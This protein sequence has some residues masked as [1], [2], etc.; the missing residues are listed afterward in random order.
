MPGLSR[1]RWR[2]DRGAIAVTT[3][4][5]LAGGVLLGFGALVVDIGWIVVERAQLQSGAD[6][7]SVGVAKACGQNTLNCATATAVVA[8]ADQLADD[9]APD[10]EATI[11]HVCGRDSRNVL[12]ACTEPTTCYGS[13]P[14][15]PTTYVEVVVVTGHP[16]SST[17]LLPPSFAQTM[18]G[19]ETSDGV[20]VQACSRAVWNAA[21]VVISALTVS[22]CEYSDAT[23]SGTDFAPRPPYPPNP[24]F[25]DQYTIYTLGPQVHGACDSRPV[26]WQLAGPFGWLNGGGTCRVTIPDTRVVTGVTDPGNAPP[27]G[28]DTFLRGARTNRT[29]IYLV[30]HDGRRTAFGTLQFRATALAPFVVTGFYYPDANEPSWSDPSGQPPCGSGDRCIS[31]FFVG[32]SVPLDYGGDTAVSIVG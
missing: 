31:G 29:V 26:R 18:L 19:S 2:A 22:T 25:S 15:S 6:A 17:T 8:L 32:P 11:E 12:A 13:P 23:R 20:E 7:A 27:A 21:P 9:N 4:L 16:N 3:A 30:V 24:D 28:C 1:R 14:E 10:G 5:V